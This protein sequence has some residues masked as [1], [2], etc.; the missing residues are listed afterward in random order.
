MSVRYQQQ[1]LRINCR[2]LGQILKTRDLKTL[3]ERNSLLSNRQS[4]SATYPKEHEQ[5]GGWKCRLAL[6]AGCDSNSRLPSF[7]PFV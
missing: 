4:Q 2:G 1:E 6:E 7:Q 3:K 5:R